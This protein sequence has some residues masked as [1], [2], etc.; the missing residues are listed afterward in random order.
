MFDHFNNSYTWP[1][2][3]EISSD[4]N[5]WRGWFDRHHG[6]DIVAPKGSVIQ[7]MAD[8]KVTFSGWK[9]GYGKTVIVQQE[10]YRVLYAHLKSIS[11]DAGQSVKQGDTIGLVGKTGNASTYHLHLEIF[12]E[13]GDRIDLRLSLELI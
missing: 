4:F 2:Q 12:D 7:S 13:E 8:G 6:V 5:E 9:K 1:V 11:V 10:T 3:G